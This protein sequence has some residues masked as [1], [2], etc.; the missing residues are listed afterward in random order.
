MNYNIDVSSVAVLSENVNPNSNTFYVSGADL[1]PPAP[2]IATIEDGKNY[3]VFSYSERGDNYLSGIV[4]GL[5]GSAVNWKKGSRIQ[6]K[7]TEYDLDTIGDRISKIE[8]INLENLSKK[9]QQNSEE[10]ADIMPNT[11]NIDN[12]LRRWKSQLSQIN[13]GD[14]KIIDICVLGDSITEGKA[15]DDLNYINYP[16]KSWLG[17]L[18]TYLCSPNGGC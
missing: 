15:C 11:Y 3:E 8:E 17:R 18:R 6:R 14:N 13:F 5:R 4:R 7:I 2:N 10:L 16:I 1:L 9:V 12:G